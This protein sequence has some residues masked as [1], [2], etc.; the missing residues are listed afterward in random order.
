[1]KKK[2]QR[3]FKNFTFNVEYSKG[4]NMYKLDIHIR[5]F[6]FYIDFM[7][8]PVKAGIPWIYFKSYTI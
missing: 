1:M 3:S 2:V 6:S 8:L 7:A 5:I 4:F